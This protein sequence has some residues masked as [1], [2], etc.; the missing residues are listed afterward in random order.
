MNIFS[1]YKKINVYSKLLTS[2]NSQIN[3]IYT[4]IIL[5]Y[6]TQKKDNQSKDVIIDT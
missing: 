6:K 5:S 2:H 4:Q 3:D 1:Q